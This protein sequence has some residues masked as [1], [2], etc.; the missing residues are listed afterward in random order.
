MAEQR[1]IA[2]GKQEAKIREEQAAGNDPQGQ[3]SVNNRDQ[4]APRGTTCKQRVVHKLNSKLFGQFRPSF[5]QC[6]ALPRLA[7]H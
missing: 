2:Q 4:A 7:V 1:P 6:T 5:G 3:H